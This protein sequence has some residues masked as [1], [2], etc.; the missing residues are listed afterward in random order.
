MKYNLSILGVYV[1]AILATAA[2]IYAVEALA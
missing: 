1:L 2:V